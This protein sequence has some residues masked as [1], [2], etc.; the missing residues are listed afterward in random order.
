MIYFILF[1]GFIDIHQEI[2]NAL[3]DWQSTLE[4]RKDF[5]LVM[6]GKGFL[7]NVDMNAVEQT[8]LSS[9]Q[10]NPYTYFALG[11]LYRYKKY[12][13]KEK[14]Y[15][16]MAIE[17]SN[18][19]GEL[20][21]L[22]KLFCKNRLWGFSDKTRN[23]MIQKLNAP[24]YTLSIL[25]QYEGVRNINNGLKKEGIRNFKFSGKIDPANRLTYLTLLKVNFPKI[26]PT[27]KYFFA[28][29]STFKFFRN[30][31]FLI[32]SLYRYFILFL[33]LLSFYYII[34]LFFKKFPI[35]VR[36]SSSLLPIHHWWLLTIFILI[37]IW[38]FPLYGII[39][40][41][42]IISPTF[43][44][45]EFTTVSL[46]LLLLSSVPLFSFLDTKFLNGVKSDAPIRNLIYLQET[47]PES[48][49]VQNARIGNLEYYCTVGNLYY[50]SDKKIAF[51]LY[52]KGLSKFRNN[53]L[54]LNN[55]GCIFA[56]EDVQD[57]A[58]YY[59]ELAGKFDKTSPIPHLN[60]SNLYIKELKFKEAERERDIA[61]RYNSEITGNVNPDTLFLM[62]ISNANFLKT[63]LHS[64]E[65]PER[66]FLFSPL[67][68]L[69]MGISCI[70]I[71]AF[72]K[73]FLKF[74]PIE[75]CAVCDGFIE[76]PK[77]VGEDKVCN[78]C[79]RRLTQ[80]KSKGIRERFKRLIKR[81]VLIRMRIKAH[82][83][84]IFLPGSGFMLI[85]NKKK[86]IFIISVISGIIIAFLYPYILYGNP[87]FS[88][89]P[90]SGK[91]VLES[92][93]SL[94]YLYEILTLEREAKRW[95]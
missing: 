9:L 36:F 59:F 12:P 83:L 7:P 23:K 46:I 57:S 2:N 72:I 91:T 30:Q 62:K 70:V 74:P 84:N 26:K 51:S 75:S 24:F 39:F 44:K 33:F 5:G 15:F 95:H 29:L 21:V 42:L 13:K 27:I 17:K 32:H 34:S 25:Y 4:L 65:M 63:L 19:F 64:S 41:I 22:D 85:G 40:S 80:T 61:Q 50:G 86:S 69:I 43:S 77:T 55:I 35:I 52:S 93:I 49:M 3:K 60:L 6:E 14:E 31:I 66:I 37:I 18:T 53:P 45:K 54:L 76:K 71:I 68:L 8:Y 48:Q 89:T 92:F 79:Y 81:N 73:K 38:L 11:N 28:Y 82:I 94:V 1:F 10:N 16:Q 87:A 20:F 47:M 88:T 56:D 90:F 67:L 78:Y 58:F